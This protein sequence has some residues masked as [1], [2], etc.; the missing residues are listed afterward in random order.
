[1][2]EENKPPYSFSGRLP[3]ACCWPTVVGPDPTYAAL[4]AADSVQPPVA[5]RHMG[6]DL[7][8]P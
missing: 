3:V 7:P 5:C 6:R 2:A 4:L 1:M 8:I